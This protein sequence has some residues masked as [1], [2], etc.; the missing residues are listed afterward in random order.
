VGQKRDDTLAM[1]TTGKRDDLA[2]R[3]MMAYLK[4]GGSAV[5]T[6]DVVKRRGL[7]YVVI[8][9]AAGAAVIVYRAQKM[10]LRKMRRPPEDVVQ[11]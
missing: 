3:G 6:A 8:R 2:R 11:R 10:Q 4:S 1:S 7:V 5:A 9:D